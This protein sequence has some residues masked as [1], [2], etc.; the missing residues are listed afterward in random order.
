MVVICYNFPMAEI[1][2]FIKRA[3]INKPYPIKVLYPPIYPGEA[4]FKEYM[5]K[6]RQNYPWQYH[7]GGIWPFVG[8]YWVML[9]A[10]FDTLNALDE[11]EKLA[12]AN[13]LNNFE[14]NEYLHGEHGTPMGVAYQSWNMSMFIAA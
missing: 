12:H 3:G 14:F 6:G 11:L 7:N 4:D 1:V 2:E 13:S 10:S 8:G 9:L 5:T